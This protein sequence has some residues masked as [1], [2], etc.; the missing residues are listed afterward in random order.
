[1]QIPPLV[2][3]RE[4]HVLASGLAASRCSNCV[5]NLSVSILGHASHCV[6]SLAVR[7]SLLLFSKLSNYDKNAGSKSHWLTLRYVHMAEL[8]AKR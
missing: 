1:M 7:P 8:W 6:T 5:R 2:L 3:K 4:C